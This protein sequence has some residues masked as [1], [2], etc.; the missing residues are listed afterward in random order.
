M[1]KIYNST[2]KWIVVFCNPAFPEGLPD[3]MKPWLT[4]ILAAIACYCWMFL[5]PI[6]HWAVLLGLF[7][8]LLFVC[9]Y[10]RG[11]NLIQAELKAAAMKAAEKDANEKANEAHKSAMTKIQ[12]DWLKYGRHGKSPPKG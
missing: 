10:I 3:S 6:P 7:T 12:Q 8:A 5:I 2:A 1:V 4:T 9:L 11:H